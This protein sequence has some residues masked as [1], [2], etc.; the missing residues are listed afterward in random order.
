MI[1]T[2]WNKL[3]YTLFNKVLSKGIHAMELAPLIAFQ[4]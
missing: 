3:G 4:L 1:V 2:A